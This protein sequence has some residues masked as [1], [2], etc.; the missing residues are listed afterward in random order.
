MT[1]WVDR[2]LTA[3]PENL[4]QLWIAAD[5]DD[6]LLDELVLSGLREAGFEVISFKDSVKFRAEYEV[7][8]RDAWDHGK[9]APSSALILHLQGANIDDIPWDYFRQARKVS[10]SLAELFPNLSYAVV[11]QLDSDMWPALYDASSKHSE[12][13]LGDTATKEFVLTHIFRL[14]PYLIKSQKDLW[15][16]LL[17]LHHAS[18]ALPPVLANHVVQVLGEAETFR[19]LPICELFCERSAALR[20]VQESWYRYLGQ[21]GVTGLRASEPVAGEYVEEI[22]VPFD[23]HDVRVLVDSM[24]LDGTLH[25]LFVQGVPQ[26]LP[27]WVKLGV[28][29]DPASMKN[30]VRDGINKLTDELP[31]MD[32]S[33]RAWALFSSRLGE[34]LARYQNLDSISADAMKASIEALL[35][36]AD[37]R[38]CEWVSKHFSDL[39][40]L[41]VAN[42]PVMVHH[43]PR[44]LSVC[45]DAGEHKIALLVFDGLALDQWVHIRECVIQQTPKFIF[46]EQVCFAW[47]PTLTSVSRQAL[48]SG[49]RPREFPDSIASTS[50]EPSL[51]KGFWN[52]HGVNANEVFY[53]KAIRRNDDLP[54][55]EVE[56]SS[57]AI[58]IT[59]LVIDTVDEIIHGAVLGKRGAAS[60]IKSW[61]ESG[62]VEKLFSLLLDKGF[63]VYLTA[64]HGNVEAVGMGRPNQ[65]VATEMR[66]ERARAYRN[67]AMVAETQAAY[68][69]TIRLHLAGLPPDFL[70]LFA[71]HRRAFVTEGDQV[72][73]HGG[74][75][76][77]ELL[78]PFIKV[79]YLN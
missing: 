12:Q 43:V 55:L 26:D 74:V 51:W 24:F 30:L 5:P 20:V 33:H 72:V 19:G 39:S 3:F 62:F 27:G 68:G 65:G 13:S 44:Y 17:R 29:Q 8:Y 73:V 23:H 75:S 54:A 7:C 63:H 58:K 79:S 46:D 34:V 28:V 6:V 11:K 78:V 60:Q 15:R 1:P 45:R 10:L 56:L 31:G 50:K 41:P 71:G 70:P 66:G 35:L 22:E 53:K 9:A 18:T 47:L 77:E 67:E 16:E 48:F 76:V 36:A 37:T 40:S 49:M 4:S 21:L 69:D 14:S 2:I 25:P 42:G 38:M 61:C 59:G 32:S 52:E 57:S 64:D